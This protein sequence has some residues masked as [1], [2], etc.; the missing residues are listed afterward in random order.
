MTNPGNP[1]PEPENDEEQASA[2]PH[3]RTV[4]WRIIV[5]GAVVLIL[6]VIIGTQVLGVLYVIVFPPAPPLPGDVTLLSHTNTDYGVDEWLYD[7]RQSTCDVLT[8][9]VNSGG[10]CRIAPFEC[11]DTKSDNPDITGANNPGQN[12]AR[13]VGESKISIFAMRWQAIIATGPSNDVPTEFRITREI[14]WS[15]EVPPIQNLN[16]P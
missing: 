7:S 8:Y 14:F 15:G 5:L 1:D 9:Y 12:I 2:D 6:A 10:E 3:Q 11:G 13:C 16:Q 4:P